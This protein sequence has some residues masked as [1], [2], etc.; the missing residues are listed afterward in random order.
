MT[1]A[2][3]PGV[4]LRWLDAA[5]YPGAPTATRRALLARQ[6]PRPRQTP[7]A[8]LRSPVAVALSQARLVNRTAAPARQPIW[9]ADL[10]AQNSVAAVPVRRAPASAPVAGPAPPPAPG[11]FRPAQHPRPPPSQFLRATH[12]ERASRL[13]QAHRWPPHPTAQPTLMPSAL[14]AQ[15]FALPL[16]A[17]RL[18]SSLRPA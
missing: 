16:S 18:R 11:R 2:A 15:P 5:P 6:C 17:Q 9:P 1:A 14:P 8:P 4:G 10:A 13:P 3:E 12:R 7:A